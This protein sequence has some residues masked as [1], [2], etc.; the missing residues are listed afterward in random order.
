MDLF[1]HAGGRIRVRFYFLGAWYKDFGHVIW[2]WD[3]SFG[4]VFLGGR[5]GFR[6][7]EIGSLPCGGL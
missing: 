6:F 3:G 1:G 2:F 4:S 7:F 5:H